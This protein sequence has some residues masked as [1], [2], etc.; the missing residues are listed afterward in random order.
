MKINLKKL[1]DSAT[2]PTYGTEYSAGADLYNLN[3]SVTIEPHT[4]KLIHSM[5]FSVT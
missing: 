3:E 2:I 4:T 1:T 5:E